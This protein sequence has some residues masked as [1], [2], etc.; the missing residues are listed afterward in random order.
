MFSRPI[1]LYGTV[2]V[3]A[4][5]AIFFLSLLWDG[6]PTRI[7]V[8]FVDLDNSYLSR[9]T[10][11]QLNS[12]EGVEVINKYPSY[13]D[14]RIA[15]QRGEIYGFMLVQEDTYKKAVNGERP[16]IT[17][18]YTEAFMVP[19]TFAYKNFL[20][21]ANVVNA[22]V[23]RSVL[24]AKGV[25]EVD[26]MPQ[27]QPINIDM[28]GIGNPWASYAIY[29]ISVLWPGILGLCIVVMTVFT[30]GFELKMRTSK[31]W[32]N[33]SGGSVINALVGKLLPYFILYMIMGISFEILI[34]LI[35]GYP[36]NGPFWVML[37]NVV[38]LI[39]SSF[40]VG[41]F[42]IGLFP[43]LRDAL[44]AASLYSVLAL[45]MSGMTFPVESMV[46]P[47]QGIAQLFPLRQYYLIYAKWGVL[48]SG[49]QD[50]WIN[51]LG[52]CLFFF[53]PFMVLLRLKKALIYQN[54]PTK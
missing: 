4:F 27:I 49:I 34:Y 45:S 7:P 18:Y 22:G 48:G 31:E 42:F 10:Y 51:I 35:I 8:G 1:Y 24:R 17:C 16:T 29:L 33:I 36:L 46:V 3:L 9:T 54:Y 39:L 50:C 12:V 47:I 13:H 15:M 11:N 25:S 52:V 44:S 40:G 19:G 5:S 23:K 26:L 6:Q 28:H 37:L 43:V 14:A 20:T 32:I 38:M 2:L 21:I 30:I 41:I 53:L